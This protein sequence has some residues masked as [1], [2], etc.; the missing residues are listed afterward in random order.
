[1]SACLYSSLNYRKLGKF[2]IVEVLVCLWSL[3]HPLFSI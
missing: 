3:A 1:L 2:F